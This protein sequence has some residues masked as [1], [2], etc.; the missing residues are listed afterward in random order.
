MKTDSLMKIK[1]LVEKVNSYQET[2]RGLSDADLKD[3]TRQFKERLCGGEKLDK[4]LPEAFAAIREADFRVMK[5]F[6]YDNQVL[7]GIVIHQGNIA[8][9]KTGEGKSLTATLPLYLNALSGKG[10]MLVTVNAYLAERDGQEYGQV[11]KFMGL[12]VAIGVPPLGSQD[13]SVEE[14]RENYNA[15]IIYT[16]SDKL[17]FDYLLEHLSDTKEG[18]YLRPFHYVVIDEVDAILLDLAQMPLVISGSPRVQSN[19]YPLANKFVTTLRK[20]VEYEFDE[21]TGAVS[22]TDQGIKAAMSFYH[23]D[24]FYD[25]EYFRLN[26]HVNLSLRAAEIFLP[27]RDYLVM[28][29]AVKLLSASTGRLLDGNK[30][31]G[32]LH[33]AIEGKE[34]VE[35]TRENRAMASITYQNLFF[36]F[37]KMAGMTGTAK[38]AEEELLKTYH[39]KV[40]EIPTFHPI[41]REDEPDIIVNTVLEKEKLIIDYVKKIHET[42]RPILLTTSSV[43]NS[44]TFSEYLLNEGISHNLLNALSEAKEAEM[45]QEA[46]RKGAVT[47]ATLMAGRGTDIKLEKAVKEIGGL[48]IVGTE[49]MPSQRIE[50]QV[51]GRSGRMGDPGSSRFYASLEDDLFVKFGS[52]KQEHLAKKR[53]TAAGKRR[54]FKRAQQASEDSASSS[55]ELSQEFDLSMV[56]QRDIIYGERDHIIDGAQITKVQLE[57]IAGSVFDEVLAHREGNRADF[58]IRFIFDNLT[59][60]LPAEYDALDLHS[61]TTV[62][63]FLMNTFFKEIARKE[64]QLADVKIYEKFQNLI[65]LKAIDEAWVEQV[66]YLEQ[67]K[68]VVVDRN[69]AQHKLEYEY[70]KEAYY[71]FE[72]MKKSINK[73]IVRLLCLS[74]I[75]QSPDGA[76]VIQFA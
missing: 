69:V 70:R 73:E 56:R 20:D 42:G 37:D 39:T 19:L 21:S 11:F 18:K 17:G 9:M 26:R 67:L 40:V 22:L 41:I 31:Q 74:E 36:M 2:M 71:A 53:I 46:G 55:R 4:L 43:K 23:L 45:V 34:G 52:I 25:P 29:G 24:N 10:A 47:V 12:T 44:A 65:F 68:T 5:Q 76:L 63:Q 14:K 62:K 28:D 33:Q 6:P 13:F 16:T 61:P 75:E 58:L 30:L 7:A 27:M 51:R 57:A 66:D 38:G 35:I 8:A 3:K 54:L 60:H 49:K 48:V 32:G 50:E 72:E 64:R 1:G 15:D 59:Y